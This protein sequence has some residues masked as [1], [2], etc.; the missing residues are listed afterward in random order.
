M[1][2]V[3]TKVTSGQADAGL[4]YVTDASGAGAKVS[5]VA[6]PEAAAAVNTYPIA[7]VA[8]SKQAANARKFSD[9]VTGP[10]GRAALAAAGFGAP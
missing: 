7:V 5:T 4:V 3:L 8:D 10:T 6:V 9:L 2:D 1:A